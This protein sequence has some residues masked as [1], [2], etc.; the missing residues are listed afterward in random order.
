MRGYNQ[1]QLLGNVGKEPEV[2]Y[3][4]DGT[5]IAKLSVATTEKFKGRDGQPQEKT[6]WHTVKAFGKLAVIIGEY[7]KKGDAVF[8]TG[9]INY[10]KYTDKSGVE[11]YFT[12]IKAGELRMIGGKPQGERSERQPAQRREPAPA[13]PSF[14][15]V[16]F[17][18]DIPFDGGN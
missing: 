16:P 12:E 4:Q 1:V 7:V 3:T 18:D 14:D 8:V 2:K 13:R 5:A 11:K 9:S 10:D 17:D 15:D 6:Q